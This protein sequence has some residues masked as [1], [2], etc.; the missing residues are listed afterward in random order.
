MGPDQPLWSIVEL[1]LMSLWRDFV[2]SGG[3]MDELGHMN[4]WNE[5]SRVTNL[6]HYDHR[7]LSVL[8]DPNCSSNAVITNTEN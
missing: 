2:L 1:S 3:S 8:G 6:G 7:E 4:T 5:E